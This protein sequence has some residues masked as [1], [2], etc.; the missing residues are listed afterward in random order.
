[1]NT[2]MNPPGVAIA[3]TGFGVRVMLPCLTAGGFTVRA[4]YSRTPASIESQARAAGVTRIVSDF[5]ALIDDPQVDLVCVATPPSQ[6]LDMATQALAAGK[7]VLCEKPLALTYAQAS[8]MSQAAERTSQIAAVDHELRF[9][10]TIARLQQA[11]REKE[12]GVVRHIQ[13]RYSSSTRV[14]PSLPWDWWSDR[15]Q[16]GGQLNALGSHM[17]DLVR[18]C[19]ADEVVEVN[20]LLATATDNRTD[21]NGEVR[22]VSSDDYASCQLRW[23]L[24]ALTTIAVSAVDPTDAGLRIEVTGETGRLTLSGFDALRLD[25]PGQGPHDLT[26]REPLAGQPVIGVNPWRTSMVRFGQHLVQ[27]L[28]GNG[29]YTGATFDD[30]AAVQRILDRVQAGAPERR[31]EG[32]RM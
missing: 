3:G 2:A 17:I 7:H 8:A 23:S 13:V 14:N 18:W 21:V 28:R 27:C 15:T 32:R 11:I 24:G 31:L 6:H 19:L 26:V 12:I 4:I 20:G 30:G 29:T 25:R 16:G 9:H 22:T 1:M 10:P 5:A